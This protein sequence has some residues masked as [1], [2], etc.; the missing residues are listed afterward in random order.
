MNRTRGIAAGVIPVLGIADGAVTTA[1]LA[2]TA[3]TAAKIA[4]GA[5]TSAKIANGTITSADLAAGA[6]ALSCVETANTNLVIGAGG[7]GNAVAPACS[8]GY[9]QTSTNCESTT[10]Q[11]P[12][13]FFQSGTCSAQN[14][15]GSDATLRASR[16]CCRVQ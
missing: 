12:F 11:M 16:T 1:K 13:V 8:A 9:V 15:S 2:D 5:V 3:V 14:N 4:D 10:W 7:T 6:V